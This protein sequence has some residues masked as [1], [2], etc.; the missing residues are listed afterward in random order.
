MCLGCR[1]ASTQGIGGDSQADRDARYNGSL[2]CQKTLTKQGKDK[3]AWDFDSEPAEDLPDVRGRGAPNDLYTDALE[4]SSKLRR[5]DTRRGRRGAIKN[6]D[7]GNADFCSACG[8]FGTVRC[9]DTC[10]STFHRRRRGRAMP[11]RSSPLLQTS[12]TRCCACA[13]STER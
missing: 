6:P 11:R 3:V 8:G 7:D 5:V 1:T 2:K 13:G 4:Q 10:P 9:C 12:G